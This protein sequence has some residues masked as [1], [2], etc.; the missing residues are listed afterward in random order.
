MKIEDIYNKKVYQLTVEEIVGLFKSLNIDSYVD[1][2]KWIV[3]AKTC[4][5]VEL[6]WELWNSAKDMFK[7]KCPRCQSYHWRK[8]VRQ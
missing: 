1:N 5:G 4:C 6:E 3:E 2:S 7:G 8:G